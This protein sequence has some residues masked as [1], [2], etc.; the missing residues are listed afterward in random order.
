[1]FLRFNDV[2]EIVSCEV[3][4][5]KNIA[6][7]KFPDG[8]TPV[9]NTS[10]FKLFLD[11]TQ[12]FDISGNSYLGF[13]TIYRNDDT[14]AEYNGY[15]LSNDGSVY[16]KPTPPEQ[17][18]EPG[19]EEKTEATVVFMS[20]GICSLNGDTDIVVPVGTDA[21]TLNAPLVTTDHKHEFVAWSPSLTG[22]ITDDIVYTAIGRLKEQYTIESRLNMLEAS[23]LEMSEVV[24]Q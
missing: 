20:D 5:N 2:E 23:V 6:T 7:I 4:V 3:Y 15:Q 16:V 9:L 11:E 22:T 17:E 1:M 21:I 12:E 18:Q 8:E 10:G 13:T 14:T 19:L 24:Y